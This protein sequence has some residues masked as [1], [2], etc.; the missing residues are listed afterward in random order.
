MLSPS[1][2]FDVSCQRKGPGAEPQQDLFRPRLP[3]ASFW[4]VWAVQR[5]HPGLLGGCSSRTAKVPEQG[6][7]SLAHTPLVSQPWGCPPPLCA[8]GPSAAAQS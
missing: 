8:P 2:P 6:C 5:R 3:E 1:S 4:S 7:I